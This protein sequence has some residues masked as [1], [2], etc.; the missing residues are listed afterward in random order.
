MLWRLA[1]GSV[2]LEIVA[3]VLERSRYK[4]KETQEAVKIGYVIFFFKQK[5][6]YEITR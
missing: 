3:A 6:A 2:T 4:Q 5:T 1:D